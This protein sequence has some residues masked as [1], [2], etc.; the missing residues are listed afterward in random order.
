M[1]KQV[2]RRERRIFRSNKKNS[3]IVHESADVIY[4][5]LVTLESRG[6]KLIDII[7]ELERRKK[8]SGYEEKKN[9]VK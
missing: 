6:V 1:F 3:N 5:F 7:T 9:R 2:Q 4:H 8:Q